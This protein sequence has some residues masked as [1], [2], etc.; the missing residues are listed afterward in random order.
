MNTI[1][2]TDAELAMVHNA[3]LTY[4]RSFGHDEA[5]VVAQV[6]Q[7]LLKLSLATRDEKSEI[8]G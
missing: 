8:V 7:I 2:L 5:E 1:Q 6:K 3:M 4:L